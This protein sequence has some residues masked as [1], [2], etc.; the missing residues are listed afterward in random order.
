MGTDTPSACCGVVHYGFWLEGCGDEFCS[1]STA[2][3]VVAKFAGEMDKL[4]PTYA[5]QSRSHG[6]KEIVVE[7]AVHASFV[8]EGRSFDVNLLSREAL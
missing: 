3:R 6:S 7:G 5:V 1:I 2:S 8:R 4:E